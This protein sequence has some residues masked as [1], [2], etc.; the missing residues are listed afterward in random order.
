MT[1][2]LDRIIARNAMLP[3]E[4]RTM[5]ELEARGIVREMVERERAA[6]FNGAAWGELNG[7][8]IP[9]FEFP[10]AAHDEAAKRYQIPRQ[11]PA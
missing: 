9:T 4:Q 7:E 10:S 11:V 3:P 6:F 2:V 5:S 8:R 1:S